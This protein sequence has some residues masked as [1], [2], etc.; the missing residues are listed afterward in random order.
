MILVILTKNDCCKPNNEYQLNKSGS[1]PVT[2]LSVYLMRL[3]A[4]SIWPSKNREIACQVT[5]TVACP[6]LFTPPALLVARYIPLV[7]DP[8]QCLQHAH[9]SSRRRSQRCN[10]CTSR[11]LRWGASVVT[12]AT[13]RKFRPVWRSFTHRI[14]TAPY[15]LMQDTPHAHPF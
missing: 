3:R 13:V 4:V 1:Q 15:K 5:G 8:P 7:P 10:S 9:L 14:F 12:R 2:C 6:L 11:R